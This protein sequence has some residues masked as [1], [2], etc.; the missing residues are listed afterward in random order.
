VVFAL[1]GVVVGTWAPRMPTLAEQIGAS[2]GV[3]GLALLGA[4]IGMIAAASL[5]GRV[6]ARFGARVVV[7]ASSLATAA[8]LPLL[9][10]VGSPLELGLVLVLLGATVGSLVR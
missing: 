9:A 10:S 4:S 5:T 1:N 8:V 2:E 3:L 6:C 7:L